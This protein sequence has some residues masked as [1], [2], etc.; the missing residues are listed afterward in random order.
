[1]AILS[2]THGYDIKCPHSSQWNLTSRS[3]ECAGQKIY[4]CLFDAIKSVFTEICGPEDL[5]REG[6]IQNSAMI[7][8]IFLHLPT[9]E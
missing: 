8:T 6:K 7:E 5:S 1:M 4:I 9:L 2:C 3:Y